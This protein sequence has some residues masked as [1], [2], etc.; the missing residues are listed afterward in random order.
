M[1]TNEELKE[2]VFLIIAN[3]QDLNVAISPEEITKMITMELLQ[4]RQCLVQGGSAI[5][6]EGLKEGFDWMVSALLKKK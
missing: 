2:I 6:G 3:K 5:T 1:L 4:E